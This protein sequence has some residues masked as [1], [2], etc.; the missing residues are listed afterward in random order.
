MSRHNSKRAKLTSLLLF[1]SVLFAFKQGTPLAICVL[2]VQPDDIVG[3]VV[4]IKA[5]C[6]GSHILLIAVVPAALVVAQR[7]HLGQR[8]SACEG[9]VLLRHLQSEACSAIAAGMPAQKEAGSEA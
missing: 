2:D 8:C 1:W 4:G 3:N 5:C 7:K 9:C 6:H